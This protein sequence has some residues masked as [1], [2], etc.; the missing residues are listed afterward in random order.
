MEESERECVKE[1]VCER[2]R[3][4]GLMEK[5]GKVK[6]REEERRREKTKK[7]NGNRVEQTQSIVLPHF[8]QK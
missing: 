5:G 3:C 7:Y 2:M 8:A 4:S 1:N 6:E